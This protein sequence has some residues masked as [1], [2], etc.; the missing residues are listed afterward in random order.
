MIYHSN[1]VFG[2]PLRKSDQER[3]IEAVRQRFNG[4]LEKTYSFIQGEVD[5]Q[6]GKASGLLTCASILAGLSYF[7]R[8]TPS[9]V[10]ALVA[11]L[12]AIGSFYSKWPVDSKA[13]SDVN[14]GIEHSFHIAVNRSL[15]NAASTFLI[16]LAVLLLA[17]RLL[18]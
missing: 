5:R 13:V 6:I 11:V 15:A 4:D 16:I 7:V 3:F 10:I 9:I 17:Y 1:Y 18:F 2:A 14:I 8:F 12:L